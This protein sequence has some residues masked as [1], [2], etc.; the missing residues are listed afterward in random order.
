[1]SE[2]VHICMSVCLDG[3]MNDSRGKRLLQLYTYLLLQRNL[4]AKIKCIGA[5][6]W[7]KDATKYTRKSYA[8]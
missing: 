5:I 8:T 4:D 3:W 6:V 1:M 7:M 2:Y